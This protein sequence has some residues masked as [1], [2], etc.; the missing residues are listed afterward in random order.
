MT[1]F[2]YVKTNLEY[3]KQLKSTLTPYLLKTYPE[4]ILDREKQ[5]NFS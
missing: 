1:H 4:I 2:S 3:E 5:H